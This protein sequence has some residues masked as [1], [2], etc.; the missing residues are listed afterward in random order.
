MSVPENI[1]KVRRPVNTVVV[2]SGR[3]GPKRYSVR[4]RKDV[5]YV[6]GGNP[7]P[8]N[9]K[10]IG[11]IVDDRF[12]PISESSEYE[13][14]RVLS[15]GGCALAKSVSSDILA[16]LLGVFPEKDAFAILSL[17]TLKVL[18]PSISQ[19]RMDSAYRRSYLS[20]Y[21]P[22]V[23]L[24]RT[25]VN[26]LF[27]RLGNDDS[28]RNEFY[29]RRFARLG[30]GHH[31]AVDGT[32]KSSVRRINDLISFSFRKNPDECGDT[33]VIYVYDIEEAEPLCVQ[34]FPGSGIRAVPYRQLLKEDLSEKVMIISDRHSRSSVSVPD[35]EN[36]KPFYNVAP[37]KRN[38]KRIN[39]FRTYRFDESLTVDGKNIPYKILE[40]SDGKFLYAFREIPED[41]EQN[42]NR[43]NSKNARPV[44]RKDQD[45]LLVFESEDR[46]DPEA[47]Y[48]CYTNRHRLELMFAAYRSELFTHRAEANGD[49]SVYGSEFVNFISTLIT[50]R[51]IAKAKSALILDKMSYG[52]VID[53]L[54]SVW[55]RT[56]APEGVLPKE[57]D[58]YWCHSLSK[59]SEL[60]IL[61]G[62]CEVP[63]VQTPK[64]RGRKPSPDKH[65]E[66]SIAV[67]RPV[68]RP[69]KYPVSD[70]TVPKR[71]VGRPRK[72]SV[73]EDAGTVRQSGSVSE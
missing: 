56:D 46:V 4:E 61:L 14:S 64:K 40:T 45:Q 38:D 16:D 15:Y 1:R 20:S 47:I 67:K 19:D 31:I 55:R 49:F 13:G 9:G 18:H 32:V 51:I 52:C 59:S 57:N 25:A 50:S 28:K 11:Y 66:D 23:D 60:M 70:V 2:D 33:I 36:G 30:S 43:K 41:S 72:N 63:P 29:N 58:G 7:Q 44:T 54:N 22:D 26:D 42:S 3:N 5:R 8:V 73:S 69:R 37:V 27:R 65:R 10:T 39:K 62:L 71:P 24:S 6:P 34:I 12:V 53:E 35:D 48:L 68:G 21:Y 17:S